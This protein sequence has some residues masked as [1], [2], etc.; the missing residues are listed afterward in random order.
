MEGLHCFRTPDC[1]QEG[2]H[3]PV[4]EY[5]H[6][7][8]GCSITGG[9]V[10][11]GE[12]FPALTGNYFYGDF[13]SGYVW[14]LLGG[15]QREW[16]ASQSPVVTVDGNITTFEQDVNGELYVLTQPGTIYHIQPQ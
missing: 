14:S 2:L 7:E 12:R 10:Y 1:Q 3:L 11:R 6:S 13:C 4:V 5:S 9:Y 8:G 15:E 16:R